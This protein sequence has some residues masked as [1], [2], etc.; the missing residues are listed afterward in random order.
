[1][2]FI[3]LK[4][5]YKKYK[6]EI[7]TAI[8]NVLDKG[9]Y[10]MGDEVKLLEEKLAKFV[11]VK[12][13]I[14]A[15]DGTATLQIALM[16]LGIGPGD[17]VIT[18]P[19]TMISTLEVIALVGAT[20]VLVD[21]EPKTF[22]LNIDLLEKAITPRTK[23]IMPVS[24]YGQMPDYDRIN[25]IA[26][27]YS[28]PVIE[29]GAQS[30]GATQRGKKS[31]G[32]TTIGSTSFYPA[33]ALGCYGD[34]GALFTNDD[35]LAAKMRAIRVHGG[36]KRYQHMYIGFTSRLDTIQAAI[37]LAKLPHFENEIAARHRI[38]DRYSKLLNDY[39]VIPYV[40]PGNTHLY[41]QYTI[42]VPN[43]EDVV[44]YLTSQGV[45]TSVHY[46]ECAH[47]Q[48]A[49]RYLGYGKNSFPEAEKAAKEV[50]SLPMHPWL[51]EEDQDLVVEAIKES[52]CA[53]V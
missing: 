23:A 34:G 26:K 9:Q 21:I 6:K 15:S 46:P 31:C 13:C 20:P 14:S 19:F 7:D 44:K 47:E 40:S 5:Q 12:H 29:D 11:G 3:D 18:V 52:I 43:R 25:A 32:V 17:E 45:P 10:I 42:R 53:V 8:H 28:L 41:H 4:T 24:L 51:T 50:L 22:N 37:L 30:L 33:K 2:E 39:C 16:A 38:G 48:P 1:M 49:Y 35:E 27:K 36:E